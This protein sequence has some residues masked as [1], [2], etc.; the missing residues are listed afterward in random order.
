MNIVVD[1]NIIIAAL[2]GSRG[3]LTLITSQNHRFYAPR[4]I[5]EEIQKYKGSICDMISL[6]SKEF[7]ENFDALLV[8]I[9]IL[10]SFE[11]ELF[12]EKAKKVMDQRDWKDSDYVA[13]AL[14]V[15]ADFI[16]TNDK[17]FSAQ[18]IVSTRTTDEFIE[19]NK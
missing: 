7:D 11:Y 12:M 13:C 1:A 2:L 10:D 17:D 15:N 9:N 3:T 18:D 14:A 6:S 5:V 19:G 8:F 16:W 4:W